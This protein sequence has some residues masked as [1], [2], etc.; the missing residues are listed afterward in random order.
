V[1]LYPAF[2]H[3]RP[4]GLDARADQQLSGGLMWALV[5]VVDSFWMMV[6]AAQWYADEE[7]RSHHI[8]TEIA[9]SAA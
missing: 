5:M 1:V 6:A 4:F 3:A 8:D 7:R 2:D 9:R